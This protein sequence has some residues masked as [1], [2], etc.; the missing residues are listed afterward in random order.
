MALTTYEQTLADATGRVI[1]EEIE[2]AVAP[3]RERIAELEKRGV[4]YCGVYQ[5][6]ASYRR[7]SIVTFDNAMHVAVVDVLPNQQPLQCSSWQLCLKGTQDRR[8]PTAPR[9]QGLRP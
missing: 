9:T 2:K 3:L 6:A 4:E 7:G 1:G 5:R 8:Q